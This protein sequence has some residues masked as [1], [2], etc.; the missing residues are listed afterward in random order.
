MLYCHSPMRAG[1]E[2]HRYFKDRMFTRLT[3]D[4]EEELIQYALSIGMKTEW[5]QLS[6]TYKF[7]FDVTG[8]RLKIVLNDDKV[9]VLSKRDFVR[10]IQ[11]RKYV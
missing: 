7:H 1:Q 2:V 11:K 4:T 3:A 9:E 5:L 6:G 8:P 10:R